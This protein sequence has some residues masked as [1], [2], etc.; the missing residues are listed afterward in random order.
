MCIRQ[1]KIR[2]E[3]RNTQTS[4]LCPFYAF[5][6]SICLFIIL[7]FVFLPLPPYKFHPS[8]QPSAALLLHR[9]LQVKIKN[10]HTHTHTH[11]KTQVLLLLW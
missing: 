4:H 11:A 7:L 8:E 2:E 5:N 1:I 10:K 9:N 3:H 6:R